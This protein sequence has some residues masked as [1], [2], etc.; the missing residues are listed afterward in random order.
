MFSVPPLP[1]SG[2]HLERFLLRSR[3]TLRPGSQGGHLMRRKGQSLTFHDFQHYQLGD[4]IRHVDWRASARLADERDLLIKTFTAEEQLHLVL[5]LDLRESMWLPELL[6]KAWIACW[7]AEALASMV[8]RGGDAVTLVGMFQSRQG[9]A[10]SP[11]TLRGSNQVA[12]VRPALQ[13]LLAQAPGTYDEPVLAAA[14]LDSALPPTAIWLVLSDFY[15]SMVPH[16]KA[17]A[18]R[19]AQARDGYRWLMAFDLDAWPMERALIGTGA[20]RINGPQATAAERTLYLD[21]AGF[22]QVQAKIEAHKRAF[23]EEARCGQA[24]LSR[25]HWPGVEAVTAAA[26]FR[27]RFDDDALLQRIFM[28]QA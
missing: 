16:G 5:T 2:A 21:D 9:R 7:M 25:W 26:Y 10:A 20:R 18:R 22:G 11:L 8:L 17:L 14:A 23:F 1:I 24:D 13:R 28:R 4:D 3:R 27:Q 6:P 12:A 19:M 15:F